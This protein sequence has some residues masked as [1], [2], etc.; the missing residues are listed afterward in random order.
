MIRASRRARVLGSGFRLVAMGVTRR[1]Q[2]GCNNR[3]ETIYQ[4]FAVQNE[5]LRQQAYKWCH[6]ARKMPMAPQSP[7]PRQWSGPIEKLG[8][9]E[10]RSL[11]DSMSARPRPRIEIEEALHN[12]W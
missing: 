6:R 1:M 12:G 5:Q 3:L 8:D 4:K 9:D 2:P 10:R 7:G 11:L